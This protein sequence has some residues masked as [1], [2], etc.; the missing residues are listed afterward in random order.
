M[1]HQI[2]SQSD[3][4]FL[5]DLL[6]E[7]G[8]LAVSLQAN[9]SIIQNRG[10]SS[11]NS[12]ALRADE[13]VL[14]LTADEEVS[15]FLVNKLKSRF[16][17]DTIISEEALP[18][19]FLLSDQYTWL[20]DP[21]DGTHHYLAN[22]SQYSIMIGLLWAGEPV[23]GWIY[24]PAFA[25]LYHGGPG[26]GAWRVDRNGKLESIQSVLALEDKP[27]RAILGRRDKNN[28][29][30]LDKISDVTIIQAGGIGYKLS[31]IL[32]DEADVLLHLAGRLKVWDTAG[33]VALA[34]AAG[35]EVGSREIDQ[36]F[37]PRDS[38]THQ[39]AIVMGK[40]GSLQWFRS[41]I[42]TAWIQ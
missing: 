24:N 13:Q 5:K 41:K 22:D 12:S 40:K 6:I 21:I 10:S 35:L 9:L 42:I 36:L 29:P 32:E 14:A 15:Q 19:Y 28:N 34:L 3:I 17:K 8:T 2:I 39:M 7:A 38:Y 16:A 25:T 1:A 37:Y 4:N 23:Y 27:V 30:W 11:G 18:K 33:P 20:V 26:L 31:R